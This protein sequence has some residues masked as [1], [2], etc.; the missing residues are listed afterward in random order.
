M[1]GS[2]HARSK[3]PAAL[4]LSNLAQRGEYSGRVADGALLPLVACLMAA[5]PGWAQAQQLQAHAALAIKALIEN[6]QARSRSGRALMGCGR[7]QKA[8]VHNRAMQQEYCCC[9]LVH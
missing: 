7:S 8:G 2:D 4:L 1:L 5:G 3:L 6:I 9:F